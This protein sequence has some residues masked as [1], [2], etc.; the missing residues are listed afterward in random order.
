MSNL[1]GTL[2][3]QV[4]SCEPS[5]EL[6]TWKQGGCSS[7]GLPATPESR[8]PAPVPSALGCLRTLGGTA[9]RHSRVPGELQAGLRASGSPGHSLRGHCPCGALSAAPPSRASQAPGAFP[10]GG[11]SAL[12]E[13]IRGVSAA[14]LGSQAPQKRVWNMSMGDE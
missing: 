4:L 9:R 7:P 1:G 14:A 11:L 8:L 3:C 12:I 10:C 6:R 5:P 13:S 2:P